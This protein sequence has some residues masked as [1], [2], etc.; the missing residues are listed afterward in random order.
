MS[1]LDIEYVHPECAQNAIMLFHGLT[2]SPFELKKY[3]KILFDKGFDVYCFLLPGHGD[4]KISISS[5][6]YQD[7]IDFACEK[8]RCLRGYYN[9]F[10]VGGLCLGAVIAL[11][12]AQN[13]RTVSGIVCF[14]TTLFLDG[15]TIPKYNFLLPIGLNTILKFFYTFVEREPYGVKNSLVRKRIFKLMKNNLVAID[16]YPLSAVDE[17]LKLSKIVQL[18]MGNV[19]SPI[20]II[21]SKEDDL[22]STKS[23][24][25]V[26]DKVKSKVKEKII[27]NNSYHLVL[28]DNEKEFIY[29]ITLEFLLN[30]CGIR[31][32]HNLEKNIEA[33]LLWIY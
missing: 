10:F 30:L 6:K 23:A 25:F 26:F 29:K 27:L 9:N 13:F 15:W 17:L 32:Y 33:Q 28:Y 14:S 2:G 16:N 22:T 5:V 1:Y 3:A 7:W 8:Y 4:S 24:D 19:T 20:M 31:Y 11:Y 18:D 12:L 21:H